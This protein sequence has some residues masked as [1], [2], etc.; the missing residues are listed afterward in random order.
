MGVE[1]VSKHFFVGIGWSVLLCA[2]LYFGLGALYYYG[3]KQGQASVKIDRTVC[4]AEIVKYSKCEPNL[5]KK[6]YPQKANYKGVNK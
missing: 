3:Y 1:R 4:M 6:V 2:I 5:N